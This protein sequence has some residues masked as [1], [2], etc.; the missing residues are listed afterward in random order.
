MNTNGCDECGRERATLY[1]E[2]G[3]LICLVCLPVESLSGEQA[4]RLIR[5][6]VTGAINIERRRR[7]LS[8]RKATK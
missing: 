1:E 3:R 7:A 5:K 2:S 6:S 8:K 4:L